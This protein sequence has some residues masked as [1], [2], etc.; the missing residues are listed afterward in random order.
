M[1][2][3]YSFKMSVMFGVDDFI[4]KKVPMKPNYH[5]HINFWSIG[6]WG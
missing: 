3:F 5:F 1:I 4:N 2:F 6:Q